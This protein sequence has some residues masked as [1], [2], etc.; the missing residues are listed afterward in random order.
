M[1]LWGASMRT[2]NLMTLAA[3]HYVLLLSSGLEYYPHTR[4]IQ[5]FLR[6]AP[7]TGRNPSLNYWHLLGFTALTSHGQSCA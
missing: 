1:A 6:D 4:T 7:H 2:V 5:T 3:I